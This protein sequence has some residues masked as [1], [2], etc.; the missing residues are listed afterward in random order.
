MAKTDIWMKYDADGDGLMLDED[1]PMSMN[2]KT[3]VESLPAMHLGIGIIYL[4][5]GANP[6]IDFQIFPTSES[7]TLPQGEGKTSQND[8]GNSPSLFNPC[9]DDLICD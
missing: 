2:A 5:P 8:P 3:I 7:S 6:T 9:H 1:A 4:I